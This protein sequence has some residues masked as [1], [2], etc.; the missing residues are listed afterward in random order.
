MVQIHFKPLFTSHLLTFHWQSKSWGRTQHQCRAKYAPP[1][2]VVERE[3][4]IQAVFSSS[5]MSIILVYVS[6]KSK[7]SNQTVCTARFKS[8]HCFS[9]SLF[10]S[11][12]PSPI[13]DLSVGSFLF[14][15]RFPNMTQ[16]VASGSLR[17]MFSRVTIQM[18]KRLFLP[19]NLY[20]NLR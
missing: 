8:G 16:N 12:A 10:F 15:G 1:M 9:P 2:E 4:V 13:L 11:L 3:G 17:L 7:G 5:T 20:K 19:Q 6:G 14:S 18:E